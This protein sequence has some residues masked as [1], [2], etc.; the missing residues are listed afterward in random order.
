MR[1]KKQAQEPTNKL[2]HNMTVKYKTGDDILEEVKQHLKKP[3]VGTA[4][5]DIGVKG[6][7]S[8]NPN[9]VK[10]R[11]SLSR[12]QIRQVKKDK[13]ASNEIGSLAWI[14]KLGSASKA[15]NTLTKTTDSKVVGLIYNPLDDETFQRLE[16]AYIN[17]GELQQS[18]AKYWGLVMGNNLSY[19]LASCKDD[20]A[21]DESKNLES[22]RILNYRPYIY[23]RDK[24]KRICKKS[25][26]K[27]TWDMLLN[28]GSIYGRGAA[29]I[30]RDNETNDPVFFN[31]LYSQLLG[32][33]V[34][35]KYHQMIGVEYEDL[36]D[37]NKF[38]EMTGAI[39]KDHAAA[40]PMN[41]LLYYAHNDK[42]VTIGARYFG[43]STLES[44]IDASETKRI[45]L[46][47][48]LK[49]WVSKS[50]TGNIILTTD[51]PLP[52]EELDAI[53]SDVSNNPGNVTVL[54]YKMMAQAVSTPT[55]VDQLQ[56]IIDA[57]NREMLR[58]IDIIGPLAGYEN[59][60]N[61]ASIAKLVVVWLASTLNPMRLKQK[62]LIKEQF[63]DEV[64]QT[65]LLQ[66]NH[67]VLEDPNTLELK[68]YKVNYPGAKD[69]PDQDKPMN[70]EMDKKIDNKNDEDN[71]NK[72]FQRNPYS[73]GAM[74]AED[75]EDNKEGN[76][77]TPGFKP[78]EPIIKE[79]TEDPNALTVKE[80]Y[81]TI[82]KALEKNPDF[83][84]IEGFTFTETGI[85]AAEIAIEI[86]LPNFDSFPEILDKVLSAVRERM[87]TKR[88]GLSMLGM[89][90][91]I[92]DIKRLDAEAEQRR[93][94]MFDQGIMTD[95]SG[96]PIPNF[97][98]SNVQDDIL[99]KNKDPSKR[100]RKEN[101]SLNKKELKKDK[102]M[103]IMEARE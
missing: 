35:N 91:Q 47:K 39:N 81:D 59:I 16:D 42:P 60:Q 27:E 71:S 56:F 73:K 21:D 40:F 22:Q 86:D 48:E 32:D 94:E 62:N 49:E 103:N 30:I 34:L 13:K 57:L 65:C 75:K 15:E 18:I 84:L 98:N 17:D 83:N 96:K 14:N 5:K 89:E 102:Q 9:L 101:E 64:F 78:N 70:P 77:T 28:L 69:I 31:I 50:H 90:D 26:F 80:A 20:Y 19:T 66:Q 37:D 100:T 7:P 3:R 82:K 29:E 46:Q 51:E 45:I 85:P 63:I 58:Y 88:K 67:L 12:Q 38:K 68:L 44:C 97:R 54:N 87:M 8:V 99:L 24:L 6:Y 41:K 33:P 76:T 53:A 52:Q 10:Y 11:K 43:I 61:Y 79:V 4:K 95:E 1:K 92:D 25:K 74:N 93:A 55:N 23:A 36:P 2:T 72:L